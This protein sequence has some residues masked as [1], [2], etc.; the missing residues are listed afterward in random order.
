MAYGAP[1][2]LAHDRL[3][4]PW[5]DS[6]AVV[7][8]VTVSSTRAGQRVSPRSLKKLRNM[9][10]IILEMFAVA[11]ADFFVGN[12]YSTFSL[13]ICMIRGENQKL[14]SNICWLLMHP[15]VHKHANLE[16]KPGGK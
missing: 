10:S 16:S 2:V 12:I 5:P 11:R 1:Y 4:Q 9:A 6:K 3:V 7:P 14:H 15:G 13:T 8:T